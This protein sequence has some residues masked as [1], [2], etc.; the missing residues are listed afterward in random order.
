MKII[1][2]G[3]SGLIG[4][5]LTSAYLES[6]HT[7]IC[8]TTRTV[9]AN[10]GRDPSFR[11]IHWDGETVG[12][13]KSYL[14]NADAVINLS[15]QSLASGRWTR[16]RKQS[17]TASR[18]NSTKA[19]VEAIRQTATKP[20]VFL[21]ASAVGYYGPVDTGDVTEDHP[22]G[23]D[24]LASLCAR[25]EMEAAKA[26]A[27]GVRTVI[28]RS[29]VV[30]DPS[31]GALRRLVLPFKFFVGGPLGTGT[32]WLPWIHREDQ[33]RAIL[34]A[35]ENPG[36][37]GPI[38]LVAPDVVTMA[39]FSRTLGRVLHRPSF[40]RVPALVLQML[41]GEMAIVVLTGQRAIPRK[42]VQAGFQFSHPAL[43]EAL[44]SLLQPRSSTP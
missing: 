7:I 3:A 40:M 27:S 19:I 28:L 22:P 38:N 41:L 31:G 37:S 25:W 21:S 35:I 13:W 9:G 24:F 12:E 20:A 23:T 43:P 30:L 5:R 10:T 18:L 11:R 15:G 32:Q 17:L 16:S 44:S 6:G 4:R 29:G 1:V 26:S 39:E 8:L 42:L 2:A 14:E 33:V 34:Y 36:I